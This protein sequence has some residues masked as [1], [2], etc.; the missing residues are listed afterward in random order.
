MT[1]RSSLWPEVISA[2]VALFPGP[3]SATN[4]VL[5]VYFAIEKIVSKKSSSVGVHDLLTH[6]RKSC[7]RS[8]AASEPPCG[9]V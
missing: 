2:F 7:L 8:S 9:I 1:N 6:Y 3:T 5:S 4:A